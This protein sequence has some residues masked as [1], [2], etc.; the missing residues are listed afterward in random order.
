MEEP[1]PFLN[2]IVYKF[3]QEG[4]SNESTVES[5]EDETMTITVESSR[6]SIDTN[7]GFLTIRTSTGWSI[8][9]AKEFYD[10]LKL[11]EN[12]VTISGSLET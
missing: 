2:S 5:N 8:N 12:G 7:G 9:D 10:L 4:N 6:G 11:V 3:N 1:K